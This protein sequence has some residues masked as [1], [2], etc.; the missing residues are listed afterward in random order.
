MTYKKKIENFRSVFAQQHNERRSRLYS[1]L[2][3]DKIEIET[4]YKFDKVYVVTDCGAGATQKLGRYM[5]E[6]RTGD[7]WG[8]KS[9]TQVNKRRWYGTLDSVGDYDWSDFYA[10]PLPGTDA[11]RDQFERES[12]IKS[13]HKKRGRRPKSE[14]LGK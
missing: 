4:G 12:N 6:S 2:E 9:W 13:A 1:N 10:R 8:I 14:S 11:E 5:V 3:P 7:I